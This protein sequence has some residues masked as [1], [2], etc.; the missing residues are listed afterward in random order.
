MIEQMLLSFFQDILYLVSGV[1]ERLCTICVCI[2]L[3]LLS[4]DDE[5]LVGDDKR[6]ILV[7]PS[8]TVSDPVFLVYCESVREYRSQTSEYLLLPDSGES[9]GEL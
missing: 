5:H 3:I 4:V 2:V 1:E 9:Y 8:C 7:D 6:L